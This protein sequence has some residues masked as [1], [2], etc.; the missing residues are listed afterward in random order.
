MKFTEVVEAGLEGLGKIDAV[1]R[2]VDPA[3]RVVA[4]DMATAFRQSGKEKPEDFFS[5]DDE[6]NRAVM[7]GVALA[8]EINS[9]IDWAAVPAAV[10]KDG[11]LALK[12]ALAVAAIL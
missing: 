3:A 5:E 1:R 11:L 10:L 6:Y 12:V 8:N 9:S 4:K 7:K 2:I